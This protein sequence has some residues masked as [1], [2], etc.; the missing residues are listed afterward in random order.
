MGRTKLGHGVL[1]WP[2]AERRSDRYGQVCLYGGGDGGV[3]IP[4]DAMMTSEIAP[5]IG[6][7]GRLLAL[8]THTAQSHHIGD[9]FRG[10]FPPPDGDPSKVQAGEWVILGEGALFATP[11][12]WCALAVGLHP[13]DG[14][15]TDWLDPMQLYRCHDQGVELYFEAVA[16]LGGE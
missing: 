6:Q 8:V 4:A 14:R 2:G 7:Q 12:D 13:D 10:F 15:D 16:L 9:L 1:S 11:E 5:F 3:A